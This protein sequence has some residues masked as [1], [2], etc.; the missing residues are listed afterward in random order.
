MQHAYSILNLSKIIIISLE[1]VTDDANKTEENKTN[2]I[3]SDKE[4]LLG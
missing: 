4:E 1:D 2:A 3:T